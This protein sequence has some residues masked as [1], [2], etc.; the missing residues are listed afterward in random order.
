[1]KTMNTQQMELTLN[2][3]AAWRT[4]PAKSARLNGARWWFGQ[5]R[6][7]VARAADWQAAPPARPEQA[8]M[9]LARARF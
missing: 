7:V 8:Y 1:M 9:P 3:K 6:I 4:K 5:M 2:H